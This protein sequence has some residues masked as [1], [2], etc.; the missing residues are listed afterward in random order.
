MLVVRD[1]DLRQWLA[2]AGEDAVRP[3]VASLVMSLTP[4]A[5]IQVL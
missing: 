3:H 1:R 5:S 4:V 2:P